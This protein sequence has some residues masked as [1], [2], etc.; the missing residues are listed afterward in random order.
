MKTQSDKKRPSPAFPAEMGV[1]L[2]AHFING[3]EVDVCP[4]SGGVW[5]D[6]FELKKFDEAHESLDEVIRL[7]PKNPKPAQVLTGRTSPRHPEAKMQQNPYGPKGMNGVLIVDTCPVC[8]GIWLDYNELQKI[9]ELYPTE[10]EKFQLSHDLVNRAFK[11]L[12]KK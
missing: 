2:E 8:A 12:H 3:V 6:R 5:F 10:A 11:T 7:L 1:Y 9:R 4:L